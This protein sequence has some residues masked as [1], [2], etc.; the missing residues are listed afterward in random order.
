MAAVHKRKKSTMITRSFVRIDGVYHPVEELD[1][2]LKKKIFAEL[3]ERAMR[4]AGYV[5]VHENEAAV[6]KEGTA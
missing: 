6:T 1:P 2:E 4:A 3:N 5:P